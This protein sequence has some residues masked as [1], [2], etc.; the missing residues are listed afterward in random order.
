MIFKVYKKVI[1]N[2]KYSFY[3]SC[4]KSQLRIRGD[5]MAARRKSTLNNLI[6]IRIKYFFLICM[7]L[8]AFLI[9]KIVNITL[10]KN[11][12]YESKIENQSSETIKLSSGRGIIYDRNNIP[13]TD[14]VKKK[15]L[16]VPKDILSGNFKIISLI[17]ESTNLTEKEIY[18]AVQEQLSSNIIEI[19]IDSI[20]ES[21]IDKLN[22]NNIVVKEKTNRYSDNNL[23]THLI[24]YVKKSENKGV[25]GIEK[26]MNNELEDSN[27]NYISVFKAGANNNGLT[28]LKGSLDNEESSSNAKHLKITIDSSIQQ[29]VEEIMDKEEN[30]SAVV[31]SDVQSGEI[32]ALCSRPNYNPNNISSYTDS[33]NGEFQNRALSITYPPGSVFKLVVLFAALNNNIIDENYVYNCT[34]STLVGK[35][36]DILS[37][38]NYEKHGYETL[39]EAFANSCNC[40]FYDIAK[41]V[42]SEKIYE[43]IKTLHL[44]EK[45]DIGIDEEV[46]SE[47]PSEI[48]LSNLAIGQADIEFTPLQINQLTQMIANNGTYKPLSI[49]NSLID[50]DLNTIKTYESSKSSEVIA[51][52]T[53]ERIKEMMEEVSKGG[54]ASL[55]SDLN[56]G[57]GVKTGTAQSSLDGVKISHGW[58]TGYYPKN[59][60]KYAIT[61]IIEGTKEESKS[62]VPFF[63]EI[64]ENLK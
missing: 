36:G 12:E 54:T 45:V 61:V 27:E 37:C 23:L 35:N 17:K 56:G 52:Y 39:S 58:I 55:L 48:S 42:G 51:P 53:M 21:K 57:C 64:C 20:D 22:E 10:L 63:K 24:G 5:K 62:A 6:K 15:I 3:C 31:I 4:Q 46:N 18:K 41:R 13:L 28:Y 16:L 38:N 44:D 9:Y 1:E 29:E 32:L 30:P 43:A 7:I 19:E 34:G 2:K 8:F 14:N 49:Y 25:S 60:P 40:A 47:I 33:T 11:E 26:Y 59:N 50:S